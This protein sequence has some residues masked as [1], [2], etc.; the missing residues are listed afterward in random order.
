MSATSI[1]LRDF[2]FQGNGNKPPTN[3]RKGN[4]IGCGGFSKVYRAEIDMHGQSHTIA[5]K[6]INVSQTEKDTKKRSRY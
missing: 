6:S 3:W 5:V 1:E 4:Q 2:Q